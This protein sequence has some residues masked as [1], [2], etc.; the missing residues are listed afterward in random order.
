MPGTTAAGIPRASRLRLNLSNSCTREAMRIGATSRTSRD[1]KRK[2]KNGWSPAASSMKQFRVGFTGPG[3]EAMTRSFSTNS[4]LH[5]STSWPCFGKRL[6]EFP[7][8]AIERGTKDCMQSVPIPDGLKSPAA[9][10]MSFSKSRSSI[11][12]PS[13]TTE[14]SKLPRTRR[15]QKQT[16][17]LPQLQKRLQLRR[18]LLAEPGYGGDYI[19]IL[20]FLRR[21]RASAF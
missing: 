4:C 13:S 11:A 2:P 7:S 5:T 3:S 17:L 19:V 15:L 9:S 14:T 1:P 20:K 8:L 18:Q 12:E 6:L 16:D 21:F 10:G